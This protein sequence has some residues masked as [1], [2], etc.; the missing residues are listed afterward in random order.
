M[1]TEVLEN[2]HR[3]DGQAAG[4]G[5]WLPLSSLLLLAYGALLAHAVFAPS[6]GWSEPQ[7]MGHASTLVF[8][9]FALLHAGAFLGWRNALVFWGISFGVS[10]AFETVGV[11]T[12]AIYGD[13][14]YS[15]MLGPK[16]FGLVPAL[17][18]LAWFMMMS[19]AARQCTTHSRPNCTSN[20]RP[21][22]TRATAQFLHF[23]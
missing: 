18:P 21:K 2:A 16:I 15:D 9:G 7:W 1:S 4:A 3:A 11:L 17:I 22:C 10:L 14:H 12:G 13:Y 6:L 20:V 5:R 8:F 19:N 23:R